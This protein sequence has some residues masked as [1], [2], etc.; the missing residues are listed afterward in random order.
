MGDQFEVE[1]FKATDAMNVSPL[2]TEIYGNTILSRWSITRMS[3]LPPLINLYSERA[4]RICHVIYDDWQN[5]TIAK[6]EPY[7]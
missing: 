4:E 7:E 6:G 1:P 5:V 3:L 2:F